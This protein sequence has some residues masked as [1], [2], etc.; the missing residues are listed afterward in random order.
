M[1]LYGCDVSSLQGPNINWD[2]VKAAGISFSFLKRTEGTGYVDPTFDRNWSEL[3]RLG[4]VRGAYQ[5][6]RPDLGTSPIAE[7]HYYLNHLPALLPGDIPCLDMEMPT[8]ASMTPAQLSWWALEWL[9][10]VEAAVGFPPLV[11][12]Y[13]YYTAHNLIDP[14][15]AHYPL[16]LA[17]YSGGVPASISVWPEVAIWQN[18]STG[19]LPSIYG[20]VD[21]DRIERTVAGLQA[22]GKPLPA[23]PPP[24]TPPPPPTPAPPPSPQGPPPTPAPAH[25][26][27]FVVT[28]SMMAR[29]SPNVSDDPS[30][31]AFLPDGK[32][33]MLLKGATLDGTGR[34]TAHWRQVM[35]G[36]PARA[37]WA[38]VDNLHAI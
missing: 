29:L 4:M 32:P 20:D 27:R 2:A 19:R 34:T 18:S 14:A 23:P 33:Q 22:L 16:W 13:P 21:L 31:V 36:T 26:P 6:A 1:T 5:F 11:Y 7:A 30:N 17:A 9:R 12:S 38:L 15:L 8:N 35:A 37:V 28:K 10:T 25:G 3:G 24:V